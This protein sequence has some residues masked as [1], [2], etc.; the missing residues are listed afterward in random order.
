[1]AKAVRKRSIR[2]SDRQA[3]CGAASSAPVAL[4]AEG[5]PADICPYR[6]VQEALNNRYRHGDAAGQSVMQTFSDR[7]VV[8]DVSD[9]GPGFDPAPVSPTS[10]G[11][12][13]L[14]ERIEPGRA[15]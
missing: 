1:M 12:A 13:G 8:V 5:A 4:S 3:Q 2:H 11:Q 7:R 10:L 14:R 6:I 15:F 9:S